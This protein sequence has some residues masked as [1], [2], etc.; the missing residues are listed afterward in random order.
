MLVHED[1]YPTTVLQGLIN[2]LHS[3]D[4]SHEYGDSCV[5]LD[6]TPEQLLEY[7]DGDSLCFKCDQ[8]HNGEFEKTEQFCLDHKIPYDRWSDRYCEWDAENV[9]YR[10]DMNGPMTTY[11][12]SR[13]NEIVCGETVRQAM[14]K[15]DA[16]IENYNASDRVRQKLTDAQRLLHDACPT[17]PEALPKFEIVA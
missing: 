7:L 1:Y 12:D 3:D 6:C 11:A 16:F 2:A 14:A 9:Y 13:R 17:L 4:A 5:S 10:P 15:V 8:A